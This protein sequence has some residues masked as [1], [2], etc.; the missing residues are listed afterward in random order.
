MFVQSISDILDDTSESGVLKN[1][2][3][4]ILNFYKNW[5]A[6]NFKDRNIHLREMVACSSTEQPQ[7]VRE[8]IGGI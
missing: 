2:K 8:T 3:I 5:T 6:R 1:F 7:N 4:I